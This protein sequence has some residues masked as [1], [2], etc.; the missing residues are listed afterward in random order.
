[1][2]SGLNAILFDQFRRDATQRKWIRQG[3]WDNL[4]MIFAY[5]SDEHYSALHDVSAE[6]TGLC[7]DYRLALRSSASGALDA[8]LPHGPYRIT[9]AKEGYGSKWIECNLPAKSPLQLRLMSQ[10]PCGFMSPKWIKAGS[11]SEIMVHS[12]EQF[13]LSLWRYG[14]TKEPAGVISWFDEHAAHTTEQ[15]LPDEDFTQCGV[16]W[17]RIGYPSIHPQQLLRAPQ[18][19]GLYYLWGRTLSGR[20][21]SFPWIVAPA[22]PSSEIAVLANTNTWNA[23]N[24]FGGR[25]NYINPAGLPPTP[26][27]CARLDLERYTSHV[28]VWM[29]LDREYLTLSFERPEFGNDIFDNTPWDGHGPEQPIEGRMQYGQAP[30]EWRLLAWL[31]REGF[32]YDYYADAQLHDGTLNLDAYRVLLVGVHPEYWTATMF[33]RVEAW[34]HNGG[35]LIYLGGNGLNCEVE[36]SSDGARMRCLSHENFEDNRATGNESRMHRTHKP[37]STLAGVA[38]SY[39]GAMTAA[40][41]RVLCAGHWAFAGTGLREGDLFGQQS[42]HERVPG[43]ASGHETDKLMP[44]SPLNILLLARGTNL[45]S[46]GADMVTFRLGKGEVFSTGSIT[47][48]SSLFPSDEVSRITRNVLCR[49][50]SAAGETGSAHKS[51]QT[52]Q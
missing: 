26:A 28:S 21:F 34:V 43:G 1:L 22:T 41:Y 3:F 40:P 14:L 11:H 16:N 35:R 12:H 2:Y 49:F 19:S 33:D 10:A 46:G 18:R 31:E 15:L 24:S 37:E 7:H 25:S 44:N 27:V 32:A 8:E 39:A 29:A 20:Q 13:R 17:N 30:G 23:Y 48:V 36:F 42:L 4:A 38:F 47:W 52:N 45:N 6:V 5:V 50:M 51:D 9:L